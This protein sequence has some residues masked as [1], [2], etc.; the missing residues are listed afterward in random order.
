MVKKYVKKT[1]R[2]TKMYPEI[3]MNAVREV[4]EKKRS[5]RATAQKYAMNYRTLG[6][7]CKKIPEAEIKDHK[8]LIPSVRVG[9][10]GL[11]Q[12]FSEEDEAA[13]ADYLKQA[14]DKNCGLTSVQIRSFAY[15]MALKRNI[16]R[17]STWDVK[18]MAGEDWYRLFRQRHPEIKLGKPKATDDINIEDFLSVDLVEIENETS[19]LE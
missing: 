14:A 9:Y 8:K 3:L 18:L 4:V 6:R 19:T 7:Y 5:L 15:Q 2:A 13:L 16:K 11:K 1:D 12:I 17:P 10:S